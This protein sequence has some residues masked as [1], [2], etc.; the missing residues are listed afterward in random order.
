MFIY[1]WDRERHSMSRE[2]A[3]REG[4]TESE[5][6]SRLWAVSIEPDVGLEPMNC[7]IMTWTEVR[8]PTDWATQAPHGDSILLDRE[9]EAVNFIDLQE[10]S[11]E[12]PSYKKIVFTARQKS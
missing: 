4:N 12:R 2:G 8:C 11:M 7:E 10:C 9:K 6:G 5:S 3:E 1:F